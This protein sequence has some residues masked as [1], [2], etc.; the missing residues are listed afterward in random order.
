MI[1]AVSRCGSGVTLGVRVIHGSGALILYL[2]II[3]LLLS[4]RIMN[5]CCI[6]RRVYDLTHYFCRSVY[7]VLI[8]GPGNSIVS[9]H[10]IF[11]PII[12]VTE[13]KPIVTHSLTCLSLFLLFTI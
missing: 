8:A 11:R 3:I 5:S 9:V 4:G 6:V 2:F 1:A 7:N 13:V 12:Q 10:L